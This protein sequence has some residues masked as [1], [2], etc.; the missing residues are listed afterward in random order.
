MTWNTSSGGRRCLTPEE[1]TLFAR[2]ILAILDESID[3]HNY[4]CGTLPGRL[5]LGPFDGLPTPQKAA[6]LLEICKVRGS[7]DLRKKRTWG[8]D[9]VIRS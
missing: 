3:I 7:R 9:L 2:A 4:R 6:V 1:R 5:A 8:L